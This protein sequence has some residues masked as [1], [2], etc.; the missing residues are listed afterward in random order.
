ME[1]GNSCGA[2]RANCIFK[3]IEHELEYYNASGYLT[4]TPWITGNEFVLL[5]NDIINELLENSHSL[6]QKIIIGS[7][8]QHIKEVNS[9]ITNP[10]KYLLKTNGNFLAGGNFIIGLFS[11][12]ETITT[13]RYLDGVRVSAGPMISMSEIAANILKSL[14]GMTVGYNAIV[15]ERKMGRLEFADNRKRKLRMY[16]V[17]EIETSTNGIVEKRW[18][19]SP[20]VTDIYEGKELLGSFTFVEK[21]IK[22]GISG[23][24]QTTYNL[25][26]LIQD[27]MMHVEY[28]TATG[29]LTIIKNRKPEV[30]VV[31]QNGNPESR[32]FSGAKLSKNKTSVSSSSQSIFK[33]QFKNPELYNFYYD[34]SLSPAAVLQHLEIIAYLFFGIGSQQ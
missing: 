27:T 10:S 20:I 11:G 34:T 25:E 17:E 6:P 4:S 28:N 15:K 8:A 22:P 18:L 3:K 33:P 12:S 24:P 21:T 30:I 9:L 29:L 19:N 32:S 23:V 7:A 1:N 26:G 14:T 31:M 5:F 16:W 13:L 2:K